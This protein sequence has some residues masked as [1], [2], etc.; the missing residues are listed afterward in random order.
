MK[1]FYKLFF[2]LLPALSWYSC[3][4]INPAE[5][6]PSYIRIN[7]ISLTTVAGQGSNSSKI[8]DAW[9][10]IDEQLVGCFE[11]PVTIPILKEGVHQLR[12]RAGIKVNG[13]SATRSPYPF[14][15]SYT[16][17]ITLNKG[18]VQ[19]ISPVV[20]YL[21]SADFTC[22]EDFEA[23]TGTILYNSPT[24]TDTTLAVTTTPSEVFEGSKSGIAYIDATRTLFECVSDPN[25]LFPLPKNSSPVFLEFNYKANSNFAVGLFC[26]TVIGS[27]TTNITKEKTLDFNPSSDWNKAYV[28]LTPTIGASGSANQ[29]KIFIGMLN[30]AGADSLAL[31]LDNIKIVY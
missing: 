26:H 9:V 29:F 22:M 8:S 6:I 15:D 16:Q 17:T 19:T 7:G 28:Y 10:Y 1:R 24:G 25:T 13:I 21:S 3:N 14:Y 12:I 27:T 11:I 4:I 30:S 2:L 5:P 31:Q 18:E 20:K 23:S